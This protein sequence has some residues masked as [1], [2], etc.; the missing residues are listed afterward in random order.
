MDIF[1]ATE[2]I[3]KF[4]MLILVEKDSAQRRTLQEL[5][6]REEEKLASASRTQAAPH[7]NESISR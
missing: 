1:I 4:K 3:K 5:L 2:N 6:R 7:N